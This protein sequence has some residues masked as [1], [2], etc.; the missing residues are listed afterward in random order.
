MKYLRITNKGIIDVNAFAL[1][2]ASTK[3]DDKTKIGWFG[4]GL[5]YSLAFLLRNRLE[6][7]FFAGTEEVIF[8]T[9][10]MPFRDETFQ[11]IVI[12]GKET[13]LT[14]DMGG[15]DWKHFSIV[16]EIYCNAIDEGGESI[17]L[18]DEMTPI[19]DC[20]TFFLGIDTEL[21]EVIDKWDDYFSMHRKN[22][23]YEKDNS[24]LFSGGSNYLV[25]RKGIQALFMNGTKCLFHYD[26][27]W[28]EIN[29]SRV[30]KD[31]W[32]F[33]YKMASELMKLTDVNIINKILRNINDCHEKGFYWD[34]HL[35]Y[36]RTWLEAINARILVKNDVA[37]YFQKTID[38]D[39]SKYLILP[40]SMVGGLKNKF[41]DEVTIIDE[42]FG[43]GS[44]KFTVLEKTPKHEYLLNEAEKF[45]NESGYK[46]SYPVNVCVFKSPKILGMALNDKIYIS[47]KVFNQGRREIA[48]VLVEENEHLKTGFQDESREFQTHFIE[49]YLSAL[50]EKSG[51]F[52]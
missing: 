42:D 32:T 8:D 28:A 11:V 17:E 52:L 49:L 29:E 46:V 4:S 34:S 43:G 18:V 36:S 1:I 2:G 50:E 44:S 22:V 3:R 51:V 31:Q 14:T 10:D 20:T 25:Y 19:D 47:E 37:G 16:R 21:Q 24:R 13:S 40:S 30:L 5:K 15:D 48:E 27:D 26:M 23:I 35:E 45:F 41:N 39:R 38:T 9:I 33:E 12:N 6:F 7:K